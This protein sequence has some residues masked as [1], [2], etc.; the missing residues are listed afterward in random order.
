VR[1]EGLGF[2]TR[3]VSVKPAGNT[4]VLLNATRS[5]RVIWFAST[6]LALIPLI[7]FYAEL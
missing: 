2:K 5:S 1:A 7:P 4:R 3:A 6:H